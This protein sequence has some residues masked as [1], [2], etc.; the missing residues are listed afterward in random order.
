MIEATLLAVAL[1][2][3]ATAVAAARGVVGLRRR[4]A[5]GLAS[6]FAIFQAGMAAL[7]WAI[8]AR[9]ARWI[10]AWDHWLAFAL[11]VLIGGKMLVEAF[12]AGPAPAAASPGGLSLRTLL[13]LS[14]ATSIDA[15]GAG[16]TLPLRDAPVGVSLA[17]IGA[18][19]FVLG[20]GGAIGGRA[21][22]ARAGRSL[23]IVGGLTLI[24]IGVKTLIDHLR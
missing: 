20:L 12:R 16:V 19:T 18:V 2:M 5:F 23:E 9:A 8:G 14:V 4:E 1:A 21:L 6:S 10:A 24:A 11:L 15:L 7:G 17:L 22:G 3:D 13:V